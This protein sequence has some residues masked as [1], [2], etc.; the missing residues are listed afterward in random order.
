MADCLWAKTLLSAYRFVPKVVEEVDEIIAEHALKS[1][2]FGCSS[3]AQLSTFSQIDKMVKLTDLKDRAIFIKSYIDDILSKISP[4]KQELLSE[5]FFENKKVTKVV[6]N[7]QFS[8]RTYYRK[9]QQALD[10]FERIMEK[11]K[12]SVKDFEK[13]YKN[14]VWILRIQAKFL[15]KKAA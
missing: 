14:D 5:I 2:G 10:D 6:M 13:D 1:S 7:G 15:N 3:F 12:Y 8:S 11:N 9:I 4:L